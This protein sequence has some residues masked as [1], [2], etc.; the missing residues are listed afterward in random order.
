[1]SQCHDVNGLLMWQVLVFED[2]PNGVAA[3]LAAGMP[4]IW[5][6]DP[7]LDHATITALAPTQTLAALTDFQPHLYGLP[8]YT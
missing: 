5:V 2:A 4:T 8:A 7:L 6:P 3:G 1:L